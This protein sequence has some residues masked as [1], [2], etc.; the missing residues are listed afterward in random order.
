MP[1]SKGYSLVRWWKIPLSRILPNVVQNVVWDEKNLWPEFLPYP[2]TSTRC[3]N[4]YMQKKRKY[5]A[6]KWN[7]PNES[8]FWTIEGVGLAYLWY[9]FGPNPCTFSP[10]HRRS[11]TSKNYFKKIWG[12]VR[13]EFFLKDALF[14]YLSE[15]I[16]F[17]P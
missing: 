17:F 5:H 4:F 10:P 15:Y 6:A 9:E 3:R 16:T 7:G 2:T 13:L 8:C 14:T 11:K 1:R 12:R